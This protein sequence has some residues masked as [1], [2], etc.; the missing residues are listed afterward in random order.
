MIQLIELI[1]ANCYMSILADGFFELMTIL[2]VSTSRK[3]WAQH[4]PYRKN[5]I[6]W[7]NTLAKACC[8]LGGRLGGVNPTMQNQPLN[9][10]KT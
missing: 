7:A 1:S 6:P 10:F 2:G 5:V 4:F 9:Y 3:P 8:G